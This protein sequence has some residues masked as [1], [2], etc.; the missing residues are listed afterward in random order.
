[1]DD[2]GLGVEL[3]LRA[4]DLDGFAASGPWN[5]KPELHQGAAHEIHCQGVGSELPK[6]ALSDFWSENYPAMRTVAENLESVRDLGWQ[7]IEN[8]HLP[9]E[10]WT[11]DYYGPLRRRIPKFRRANA[12]D[13]DAQAVADL[14]E[15]EMSV[16]DR[17]SDY[18]GCEFYILRRPE[19]QSH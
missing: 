3:R 18:Y 11:E 15:L 10:A 7:P 4:P 2:P 8:F 6:Q 9:V 13:P 12:G 16:L 19:H 1:M 5:E 14:T 17:F